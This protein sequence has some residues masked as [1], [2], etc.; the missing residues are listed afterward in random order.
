MDRDD[1]NETAWLAAEL[2]KDL[3]FNQWEEIG[4]RLFIR[5]S[6]LQWAIGDWW[7]FG[8][9]YDGRRYSVPEHFGVNYHICENY[10]SVARAFDGSRR[11]ENLSFAHHAEVTSLPPEEADALLDWALE[12]AEQNGRP[13]ARWELRIEKRMRAKA[14][15]PRSPLISESPRLDVLIQRPLPLPDQARPEPIVELDN[16]PGGTPV[17]PE[18]AALFSEPPPPLDRFAIA[19]AAF[20]RLT[21]AEQLQL[22]TGFRD[23]WT[24]QERAAIR[25]AL[26]K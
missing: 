7:R 19:R 6:R 11:R 14:A 23:H 26:R 21:S 9:R 5:H 17:P 8:E 20:E 12:G 15:L 4:E 16:S 10:A 13:R 18:L 3:S 22:I 2:K 25:S 24:P 1:A